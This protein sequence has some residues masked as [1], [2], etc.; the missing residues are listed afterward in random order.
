MQMGRHAAKNILLLAKSKETKQFHYFDK[1]SMATIGRNKAIA[2]LKFARFG[3]LFAWL[4]W[5]FVHLIFL[6]GFRNRLVVFSNGPGPISRLAVAQCLFTE[7]FGR[8]T[9]R[10]RPPMNPLIRL[11]LKGFTTLWWP[12]I[13][14]SRA[15]SKLA[16]STILR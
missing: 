1:G 9:N 2:D 14:A 8:R 15:L 6:V 12:Q 7:A 16:Q 4:T 3:G 5:L 10:C 13:K 11:N